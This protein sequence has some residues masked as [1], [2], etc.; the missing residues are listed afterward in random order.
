MDYQR[1]LGVFKSKKKIEN[2]YDGGKTYI[3]QDQFTTLSTCSFY[4]SYERTDNIL[5]ANHILEVLS[6]VGGLSN[7]IFLVLGLG[8]FFVN[9][10]IMMSKLIRC[11]FFVHKSQQQQEQLE[12][13]DTQAKN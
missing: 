2:S 11:M 1:A 3:L 6:S 12:Q 10:R 4:L 8:A 13:L 5:L 7:S 9:E